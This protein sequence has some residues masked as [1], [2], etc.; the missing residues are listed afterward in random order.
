MS[1]TRTYA[2]TS[3][4]SGP[5]SSEATSKST[6]AVKNLIK[7]VKCAAFGF[8]SFRNY[9]IRSLLYA[10]RSNWELHVSVTPRRFPKCKYAPCA[11]VAQV[12]A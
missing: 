12:P 5:S 4:L 2:P 10:G 3:H 1:S 8:T 11:I 7:R 9:R 6:E